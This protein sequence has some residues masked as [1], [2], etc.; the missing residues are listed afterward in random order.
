VQVKKS[1]PHTVVGKGVE[2]SVNTANDPTS[3][4]AL[5]AAK[6]RSNPKEQFNNL[7]HHLNYK[8]VEECIYNIPSN[9]AVGTDGMTVGQA[10]KNLSWLLPPLLKQIHKGNYEA[11]PV[12]RVY[13]PKADGKQRP[14]GVPEVIDRSIQAGASKILSAIYEQDFLNCSF[15][16]RPKIGCHH[17]LATVNELLHKWKLNYALEVDIRDFFGSLSHEWLRKFLRL[18]ISDQRMLKLIDVWLKAGVMEKDKWQE[19]KVGTPQGGAVS[20]ILANVYLHYV[21][22]LWFERKVK[23]SLRG[24]A[25][26]V[27]YADDFVIFFKDPKDAEDVRILLKARLVQFGLTMAE[28]KTHMTD[29]TPRS[30]TGEHVRRRLTFLGFNIFRAVNRKGT[31]W[32]IVFQTEGKR[33]TRAKAAMKEKL[34]RMMHV[35]VGKQADVINAM[36]SGHF[37]YY[38][39]AGNSK[40][41]QS[42]WFYTVRYWRHCLSKRSQKGRVNWERLNAILTEYP[43]LHPRIKISYQELSAYVRL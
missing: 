22:D 29:M 38:G 24:K 28:D 27:R 14:I 40:K 2:H 10:R 1:E 36:L 11:P 33:F 8:L 15:G 23:R 34:F 37:N 5:I 31:A 9:S 26:L 42:F 41:L 39:L 18:R 3:R 4:L 25:Q 30:N 13:I 20:P 19:V 6:A 7:I 32:K 17:A 35:E 16:F 21:L 12:R 43:L